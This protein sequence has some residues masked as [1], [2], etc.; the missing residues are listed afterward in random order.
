[1]IAAIEENRGIKIACLEQIGY[2]NGW[3]SK[4]NLEKSANQMSKNSYGLY[5]K[6]T[7]EKKKD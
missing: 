5:L 2:D 1:M 7:L 6:R 3:I 4:E